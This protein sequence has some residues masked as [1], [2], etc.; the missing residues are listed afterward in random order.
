V[1]ARIADL[2]QQSESAV[3][4]VEE[5]WREIHDLQVKVARARAELTGPDGAAACGR[6]AKLCQDILSRIEC[7]FVPTGKTGRGGPGLAKS[8]LV[9]IDFQPLEGPSKRLEIEGQ[10]NVRFNKFGVSR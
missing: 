10:D 5:T 2:K 8:K 4:V 3:A 9:A 6:K 1:E 7:E